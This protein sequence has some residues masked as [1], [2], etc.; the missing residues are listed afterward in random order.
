MEKAGSTKGW[1]FT[2]FE[3][4]FNQGYP[5]E[6][7]HFIDCVR[8]DKKPLVTG[9]DGRA[10]LE[11]IYAAY[12][13]AGMGKKVKLPFRPKGVKKPVDLWLR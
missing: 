2:I 3:E 6:L 1:T 5:Q 7:A 9:E 12:A 13:S 8:H 10:V 11:L 4:A